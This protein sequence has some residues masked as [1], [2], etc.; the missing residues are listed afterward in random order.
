MCSDVTSYKLN[1]NNVCK[2]ELF[3]IVIPIT[4]T[5]ITKK[6]IKSHFHANQP[7]T[8]QISTFLSH[9]SPFSRTIVG[10]YSVWS[11]LSDGT[12]TPRL[13]FPKRMEGFHLLIEHVVVDPTTVREADR[14]FHHSFAWFMWVNCDICDILLG[15]IWLNLEQSWEEIILTRHWNWNIQVS[16]SEWNYF[17]IIVWLQNN[18]KGQVQ[19]Y[20]TVNLHTWSNNRKWDQNRFA[21]K[22]TS[23]HNKN[24]Q[25]YIQQNKIILS[26]QSEKVV[27]SLW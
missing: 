4:L 10:K 13:I 2:F 8:S 1:K 12:L 20:N 21:T 7:I 18:F 26:R 23:F 3:C 24:R 15:Q 9:F 11:A 5:D 25:C 14:E 17:D 27:A 19:Q 6:H 22:S 16:S